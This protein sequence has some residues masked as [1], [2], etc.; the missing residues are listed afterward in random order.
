MTELELDPPKYNEVL[1]KVSV[2]GVCQTD[3]VARQQIIPVPL[4]SVFGHA[5]FGGVEDTGPGVTDFKKGTA[6][7]FLKAAA[8]PAR[9][10]GPAARGR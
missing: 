10:A 1:V 4:P 5:G 7:A 9:L 3:E 6:S 2:C 8:A